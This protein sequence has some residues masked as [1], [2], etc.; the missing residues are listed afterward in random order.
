MILVNISCFRNFIMLSQSYIFIFAF[1][2]SD[3]FLYMIHSL[4]ADVVVAVVA[5]FLHIFFLRVVH[6][7][8]GRGGH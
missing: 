5:M 2:L 7:R 4:F 6:R 8:Q 3:F 1:I